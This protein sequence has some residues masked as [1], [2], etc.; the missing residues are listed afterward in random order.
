MNAKKSINRSKFWKGALQFAKRNT[1]D[2]E[3]V[4]PYN[5]LLDKY[6]D[7]QVDMVSIK[8]IAR[9]TIT[10]NP[11]VS[12]N[13]IDINSD[14]SNNKTST[15]ELTTEDCKEVEKHIKEVFQELVTNKHIEKYE[16]NTIKKRIRNEVQR[17]KQVEYKDTQKQNS[18]M[19][20]SVHKEGNDYSLSLNNQHN[21]PTSYANS[22]YRSLL[23][24]SSMNSQRSLQKTYSLNSQ[25]NSYEPYSLSNQRDTYEPYSL[26]SQRD[27]YELYSLSSQRD[28]YEP[29]SLNSQGD[30][31]NTYSLNSQ[32]DTYNT[33][34]LNSQGDTYNTYSIANE[35]N[36]CEPY[37]L[38]DQLYGNS[39]SFYNDCG[40][41]SIFGQRDSV[42]TTVNSMHYSN[43]YIQDAHRDY[44]STNT[45]TSQ[46]SS[47]DNQHLLNNVYHSS[48]SF[49]K[50]IY[51]ILIENSYRFSNQY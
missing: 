6:F 45:F 25:R 40:S 17:E 1:D 46:I 22:N 30:T 28:T 34:S 19:I 35:R 44:D 31:Y 33:Y 7:N 26:S 47:F 20:S 27:T 11:N 51:F 23:R 4:S 13:S 2:I 32:R 3:V 42:N 39:M 10:E 50:S 21:D 41:Q 49:A 38:K 24:Q 16:E 8:K 9:N 29:Y 37:S 43:R 18:T 15:K 5:P 14:S 12:E 48:K 36:S